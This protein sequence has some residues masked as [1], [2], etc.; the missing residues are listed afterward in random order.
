MTDPFDALR[1]PVTPA[2]PDPGFAG[3]LRLRL[4]REVLAS[5]GEIMSQQTAAAAV[6]REPAAPPA[7]TP[8]IVVADARR[9][10]DWYTEVLGAR[11]R[12]ST[13]TA[14]SATPRWAL[15]TGC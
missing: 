6:E 3:R 1:E 11:R 4:T 12:T 7:L 15:A 9:A 2:D 13:R 14:R 10:L 5:P 8:Y